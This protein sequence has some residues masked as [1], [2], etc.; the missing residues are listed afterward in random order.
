MCCHRGSRARRAPGW[1]STCCRQR[2]V[3]HAERPEE[4]VLEDRRERLAVDLLG[5]EAEQVVVGVVIFVLGA[6]REFRRPL[7]R[8]AQDLVRGPH[9]VRIV[10]EALRKLRRIGEIEEAGPHLEELADR[11]LVPVGNAFD[12]FRDR[13]VEAQFAFL[14]H[15]HDRGRGHRLGVRGGAEVGVGARRVR[16]A[17]LGRSIAE[18]DVAL[19][20]REQDHGAG[21]H[22]I[23]GQAFDAGLK[24]GRVDRLEP[25]CVRAHRR[26]R[27]T[28]RDNRGAHE[29]SDHHF[30]PRS[31]CRDYRKRAALSVIAISAVKE[32]RRRRCREFAA[33]AV[34]TLSQPSTERRVG[35]R[36]TRRH[37]ARD[38]RA[39]SRPRYIFAFWAKMSSSGM[40]MDLEELRERRGSRRGRRRRPRP[41]YRSRA[42][43]CCR[44]C[45]RSR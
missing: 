12:I 3:L 42:S 40:L 4:A 11:D 26:A 22:E 5:D 39:G 44:G 45:R 13:I 18:D 30:P 36:S 27:S 6:R 38:R 20:R 23:L 14:D 9:L 35:R 10:V 1:R 16:G 29:S 19:R 33:A 43:P 25:R 17:K 31:T 15:L 37:G 7:E 8:H 34:A 32:R 28:C 2:R 21:Q 41:G 24:R